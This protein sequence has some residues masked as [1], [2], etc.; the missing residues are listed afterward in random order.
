MVK[1]NT[2][3]IGTVCFLTLLLGVTVSAADDVAQDELTLAD[4]GRT[5]YVITPGDDASAPERNAAKDL[6]SYLGW[7]YQSSVR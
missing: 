5:S 2:A 3:T 6:A 4:D 1:Q 7:V